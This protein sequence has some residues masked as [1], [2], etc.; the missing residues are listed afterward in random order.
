M[1]LPNGIGDLQKGERYVQTQRPPLSMT[2]TNSNRYCNMDIIFAS[3]L[4]SFGE[5]NGAIVSYDIACQWFVNMHSRMNGGW[6]DNLK[7]PNTISL[8]PSI[9]SMHYE[10]HAKKNHEEFNP[11]LVEGNGTSE[12]EGPE[13][14][15][16]AHNALGNTTKTMGPEARHLVLDDNFS[17]WNWLKYSGHGK[18]FHH[19]AMF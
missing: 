13:R 3:A 17:F 14:I 8:T 19:C 1:I 12:N 6:P 5:I 11:R 16:G 2:D 15:W 18:F 7:I 9:P 10:G 4:K